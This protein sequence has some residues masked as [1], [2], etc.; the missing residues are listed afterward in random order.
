ML[1]MA[2]NNFVDSIFTG[3]EKWIAFDNTH[4]GLD[5]LDSDRI[6]SEPKPPQLRQKGHA[7]RL[8]EY[9]SNRESRIT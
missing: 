6:T 4:R 7:V 8:V 9:A 5:W 2:K 3:D 1:C